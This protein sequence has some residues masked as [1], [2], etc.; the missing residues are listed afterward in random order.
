MSIRCVGNSKP[1]PTFPAGIY[2]EFP[3]HISFY[4]RENRPGHATTLPWRQLI[5]T[6]WVFTC[7][8]PHMINL[9][10]LSFLFS[11]AFIITCYFKPQPTPSRL[12]S[13]NICLCCAP[14]FSLYIYADDVFISTS[15]AASAQYPADN[16]IDTRF[17]IIQTG[18][19]GFTL[20][21][22]M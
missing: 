8:V 18:R 9:D 2:Y 6:R 5:W 20:Q 7:P 13:T 12:T 1:S 3:L 19:G 10:R 22:Q 14:L 15:S 16:S 17:I 21:D 11:I 4:H